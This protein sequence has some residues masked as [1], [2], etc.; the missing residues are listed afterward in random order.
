VISYISKYLPR[1]GLGNIIV[2]AVL[3][4]AGIRIVGMGFGFLVGV[5][6]ARY[7]G[8][9]GYGIYGI[10]MSIISVLTVPTEFGLPRLITREVAIAQVNNDWPKIKGIWAWAIKKT[11]SISLLIV[12]LVFGG[13]L[14]N[15]FHT[16]D[17]LA[18]TLISGIALVPL[19]SLGNINSG[20]LRGMQYVVRSQF[21]EV[22]LR[23]V[24]FSAFLY[25]SLYW[26]GPLSPSNAIALS[27]LSAGF[28]FLVTLFMVK[29]EM[30][31]V[32][33]CDISPAQARAWLLSAFPM[34]LTDG[35]RILQA[36]LLIFFLGFIATAAT[37]GVYRVASSLSLLIAMPITL[38]NIVA[39]PIIA[40]LYA[41]ADY[42]RLRKM[43]VLISFFMTV[44]SIT[45]S[46]PFF[47]FGVELIVMLFGADFHGS[48]IVLN[49]LCCGII[50]SSLFGCAPVLLNMTG[51]EKTVF[52]SA[53]V[54]FFVLVLSSPISIYFYG[55]VGAAFS[56]ILSM[57]LWGISMRFSAKKKLNIETSFVFYVINGIRSKE[58]N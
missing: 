24:L 18:L 15:R 8:V 53:M 32:K 33:K 42:K 52:R 9:E 4:S 21:P 19:V 26:F 40:R 49:I 58:W 28:V 35:M 11:F 12:A 29:K 50:L 47:I 20:S 45:L 23:P 44:F 57:F 31:S 48:H 17:V 13:V 3:G 6:L 1:S 22:V 27:V 14:I 51:N 39:A 56:S 16:N 37:V 36:N 30:P 7:L 54:A 5:Q 46:L 38:L 34:A 2:R 10:A 25:F 55:G 43:L 41:E